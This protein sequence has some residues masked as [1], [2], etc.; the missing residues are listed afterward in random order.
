MKKGREGSMYGIHGELAKW[1]RLAARRS[2]RMR[3]P[4]EQE[5]QEKNDRGRLGS[6][7]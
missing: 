4:S 6:F 3:E 5:A 2:L 7:L 1:E